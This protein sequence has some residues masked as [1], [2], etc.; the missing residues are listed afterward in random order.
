VARCSEA[1][2]SGLLSTLHAGDRL[3][4]VMLGQKSGKVLNAWIPAYDPDYAR[5]SPG[6]LLHQQLIRASADEGILRIELGRGLNPLKQTLSSSEILLAIGNADTRRMKGAL[7]R[8][9]YR[10]KSRLRKSP[11]VVNSLRLY[12]RLRTQMNSG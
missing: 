10:V 8:F 9:A 7:S 6:A 5:Y 3:L 4:A 11:A 12:R 2:F 1:G